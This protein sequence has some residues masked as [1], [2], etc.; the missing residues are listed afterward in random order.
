MSPPRDV[1]PDG[2]RWGLN[3]WGLRFIVRRIFRFHIEVVGLE[4]VPVGEPVIVAA[5]PHRNWLDPF[6]VV[7]ALPRRPRIYYLG[8]REAVFNTWWKRLVLG[9]F[10]G[11]VPVS[12]IGGLNR[13]ALNTALG[14]LE[15]G[16]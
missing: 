14:V 12:S 10:G 3:R 16:A 11:V 2:A 13:E 9:A 6:L 1:K 5:A 4:R 8:S 15:S 7:L